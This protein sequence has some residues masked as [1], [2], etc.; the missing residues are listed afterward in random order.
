M[1]ANVGW[2]S[3]PLDISRTRAAL[4]KASTFAPKGE[5]GQTFSLHGDPKGTTVVGR[6]EPSHWAQAVS[7]V[8]GVPVVS[9]LMLEGSWSMDIFDAG[10]HILFIDSHHPNLEPLLGGDLKTVAGIFGTSPAVLRR[11]HKLLLE[12]EEQQELAYRKDKIPAADEWG[13]CQLAQHL[14]ISNYPDDPDAGDEYQVAESCTD[15]EWHGLPERLSLSVCAPQQIPKRLRFR[16]QEQQRESL[17]WA[18][19]WAQ[20]APRLVL[21]VIEKIED[22]GVRGPA[23]EAKSK[24]LSVVCHHLLGNQENALDRAVM[25]M[26]AWLGP[27]VVGAVNQYVELS[28]IRKVAESVRPYAPSSVAT[29]CDKVMASE[30]PD[31]AMPEGDFF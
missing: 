28:L 18:E 10:E 29:L 14:G 16:T 3:V 8:A 26:K 13:C 19:T 17:I 30:E 12:D 31:L 11:F 6:T 5:S 2:F 15:S 20:L 23:V 22:T 24:A 25:L 27:V 4:A 7:L 21:D 1:S 9:F